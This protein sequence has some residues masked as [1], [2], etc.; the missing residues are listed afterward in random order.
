MDSLN[1]KNIN[2]EKIFNVIDPN[3]QG[4]VANRIRPISISIN[5]KA[6][7]INDET[8]STISLS[9]YWNDTWKS[10]LDLTFNESLR[11]EYGKLVEDLTKIQKDIDMKQYKDA[12]NKTSDFLKYVANL[13]SKYTAIPETQNVAASKNEFITI[14]A[15]RNNFKVKISDKLL[16]FML[17]KFAKVDNLDYTKANECHSIN[18]HSCIENNIDMYFHSPE[19]F[20]KQA[21][22]TVVKD[23]KVVGSYKVTY[24]QFCKL[25]SKFDI[26][27]QKLGYSKDRLAGYIKTA[28]VVMQNIFFDSVD[29]AKEWQ[30]MVD[31]KEKEKAD[32]PEGEETETTKTTETETKKTME[33]GESESPIKGDG[34]LARPSEDFAS[35]EIPESEPRQQEQQQGGQMATSRR[36]NLLKKRALKKRAKTIFPKYK[37]E[38]LPQETPKFEK[39]NI[40]ETPMGKG[41]IL[42]IKK[43]RL[44]STPYYKIKLEN[45][46][47]VEILEE[48]LTKIALKKKA[49]EGD[50][51]E[52]DI[53][54][55]KTETKVYLQSEKSEDFAWLL[56]GSGR[57]EILA[58]KDLILGATGSGDNSNGVNEL[59]DYIKK[60]LE[61]I[62]TEEIQKTVAEYGTDNVKEMDRDELEKHLVWLLA[63]DTADD[64]ENRLADKED[65]KNVKAKATTKIK[66]SATDY[67]GEV[68]ELLDEI[69][70]PDVLV[71]YISEDDAKKICKEL[72]IPHEAEWYKGDLRGYID[73]I[74]DGMV[75][76]LIEYIS[77][78][79]AEHI[80]RQIQRDMGND[81]DSSKKTKVKKQAGYTYKEIYNIGYEEGKKAGE[82][83]KGI[84]IQTEINKNLEE[85]KAKYE[86]DKDDM[87]GYILQKW[88][89]FEAGY[90][91]GFADGCIGQVEKKA[92]EHAIIPQENFEGLWD[93]ALKNKVVFRNL[94]KN[95]NSKDFSAFSKWVK[96]NKTEDEINLFNE[97]L[98]EIGKLSKDVEK[99]AEEVIEEKIEEQVG[100][101]GDVK[102][103]IGVGDIV[104]INFDTLSEEDIAK[105]TD[106]LAQPM[107]LIETDKEDINKVIIEQVEYPYQRVTINKDNVCIFDEVKDGQVIVED[108][109]GDEMITDFVALPVV[110]KQ[111]KIKS[112]HKAANISKKKA[113]LTKKA[114]NSLEDLAGLIDDVLSDYDWYEYADQLEVG[115]KSH[116]ENILADLQ[117][118]EKGTIEALFAR[119]KEDGED[120]QSAQLE[121]IKEY[122]NKKYANGGK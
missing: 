82:V 117:K 43:A 65:I 114:I 96:E 54:P 57:I 81:I 47:Q 77:E 52:Q 55:A 14:T 24:D 121:Q 7:T 59:R 35:D 72:N 10:I 13:S 78:S 67:K 11:Q 115:E 83:Y 29:E 2:D 105:Y 46:K 50:V 15:G 90:S 39:G 85:L 71:D 1:V 103:T 89:S 76:V 36:L 6:E 31:E 51:Q 95:M 110:A 38:T 30:E 49:I 101:D 56:N 42:D 87:G 79:D 92:E 27:P 61:K 19:L 104:C 122:Y 48:E 58:P 98:N 28:E 32:I 80:W 84:N 34:G 23:H 120:F 88:G 16:N 62:P 116:F 113:N 3:G 102:A 94:F 109:D 93:F 8:D 9:V 69:N 20:Q 33:E 99:K 53:V 75:D 45:G 97:K 118:D 100:E 119:L 111:C 63:G 4:D 26:T 60:D 66:K 86:K 37:F 64:L 40:V 70:Q 68:A 18:R 41:E 5:Q 25:A 12:E 21:Y 44:S 112:I 22:M 73:E 91:N 74:P 108:V 17:R 106:F 107:L